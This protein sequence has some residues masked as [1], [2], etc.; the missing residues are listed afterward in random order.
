[1]SS[2]YSALLNME[3]DQSHIPSL[4]LLLSFV[5]VSF[6]HRRLL[7][8]NVIFFHYEIVVLIDPSGSCHRYRCLHGQLQHRRWRCVQDCRMIVVKYDVSLY[9]N[10]PV[11]PVLRWYFDRWPFQG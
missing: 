10:G 5:I 4:V 1:M 7:F 2:T 8:L 9:G 11:I 6:V 3:S